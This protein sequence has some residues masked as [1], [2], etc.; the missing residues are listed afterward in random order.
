MTATDTARQVPRVLFVVGKGGVGRSTVA[1]ALALDFAARGERVLLVEWTVTEVIS[2]WF[3]KPAVAPGFTPVPLAPRLFVMN[4]ELRAV[5]K[6][7]FVEHLGLDVFYRRVI[8]GAAVQRLIEAAPGLAELLFIGQLWWLT[9]LAENE[10]GLR[11]DRIVVDAPATGHAVSL[12]DLPAAMETFGASGLLALEVGRIGQMMKDPKWTGA[13]VV[14]LPEALVAEETGELVPR[15][16]KDLG[17]PPLAVF[18]NRS[19]RGLVRPDA[20]TAWLAALSP[21]PR[22]G[23]RDSL[24]LLQREL[25]ARVAH[26][27]A[28]RTAMAGQTRDGVVS[29]PE[30]LAL[31]GARP[32]LEVVQALAP[33]VRAWLSGA[34]AP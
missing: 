34:E 3:G 16:A 28:L 15:V 13:V 33:A 2:P 8:E 7:Y 14:S 4:Y 12:L 21:P 20:D 9:T 25:S 11:F 32:P 10:A 19:A 5:L 23:T 18:V 24:E 26:E 29:L 1:T 17:R 6:S 22:P 27:A 31:I 30:Q